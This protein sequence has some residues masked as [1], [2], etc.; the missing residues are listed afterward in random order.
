MWY[1]IIILILVYIVWLYFKSSNDFFSQNRDVI[2][3]KR[4]HLISVL[5]DFNIDVETETIWLESFDSFRDYPTI[6]PFDGETIVKDNYTIN[7]Y[8]A[9]GG[10]HDKR[11]FDARY[12]GLLAYIKLTTIAD[13]QYGLDQRKLKISWFT[14]WGRAFG[15]F[16]LKPFQ[17]I[18]AAYKGKLR[19][20]NHT[21]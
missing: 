11:Y 17:I 16:L 9:P 20:I 7:G 5:E 10:N 14:A 15:V 19:K 3:E 2:A 6:Y 1:A 12:K 21:V 13:W 4:M 18:I 8:S